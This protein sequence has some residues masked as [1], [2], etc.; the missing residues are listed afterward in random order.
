M[1][2]WGKNKKE[3][4][5]TLAKQ[6][7]AERVITRSAFSF[8]TVTLLNPP[9]TLYCLGGN[10]QLRFC[11]ATST[12][13]KFMLGCCDTVVWQYI[14]F[15]GESFRFSFRMVVY[16]IVFTSTHQSYNKFF[17]KLNY[18]RNSLHINF[19]IQLYPLPFLFKNKIIN[20]S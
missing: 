11:R 4:M 9:L 15:C 10:G 20:Y 16:N 13:H 3:G 8:V 18:N 1:A 2:G 17:Q 5:R 6:K 19:I 14:C 7:G 12:T